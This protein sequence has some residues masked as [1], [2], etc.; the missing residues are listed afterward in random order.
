ECEQ[1]AGEN[2]HAV[3][4]AVTQNFRTFLTQP[5]SKIAASMLRDIERG[6]PTE[7]DHILGDMLHRA[8]TFGIA[9]P[10]L[11]MAVCHLEAYAARQAMERASR[12]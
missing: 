3:A 10:L 2:G 12:S 5:G 1:V 8:R 11:R 6:G 4:P 7:G 9:A